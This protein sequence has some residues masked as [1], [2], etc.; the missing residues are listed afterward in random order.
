MARDPESV[1][2]L[3]RERSGMTQRLQAAGVKVDRL[4][5]EQESAAG[6]ETGVESGGG[7]RRRRGDDDEDRVA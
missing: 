1:G 7:K 4:T 3:A 2:L 5:V 6:H